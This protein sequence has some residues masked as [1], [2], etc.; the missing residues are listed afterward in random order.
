MKKTILIIISL[1][2]L[3]GCTLGNTPT[4]R[5]EDF[6]YKYQTGSNDI[7]INYT[8]LTTD[9]NLT[10]K[11][12]E[13]YEDIIKKQYKDLMYE[14]KEETIDGNRA[15]V[16]IA[17]EVKNFKKAIDKYNQGSYEPSKYHNLIIEELKNT[18]EMITYTLDITLTKEN[19]DNWSVDQLTQENKQKL[20]GIY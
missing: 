14:I 19:D 1:S 18:K 16:T 3:A 11:Q 4:S 12:M 13:D 17:I 20:L 15:T 6:L 9:I 2:L 7:A 8:D 5:V 10:Q